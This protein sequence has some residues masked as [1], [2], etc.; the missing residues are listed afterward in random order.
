M[1]NRDRQIKKYGLEIVK[2]D[3]MIWKKRGYLIDYKTGLL[4]K[5][6]K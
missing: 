4:I 3:E 6:N 1:T 2:Q 5:I